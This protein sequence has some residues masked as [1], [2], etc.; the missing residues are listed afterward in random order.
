MLEEGLVGECADRL[1]FIILQVGVD[2]RWVWKLHSSHSY[3]VKSAYNYLTAVDIVPN[4]GFN[5]LLWL[6]VVPLKVNIFV[7]R[8]FLNRFAMKDNLCRRSVLVVSQV[9]CSALCG[10]LEDMD[11]LFF[12]C[13]YYGRL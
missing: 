1:S 9:S 6:K 10:G 5:H 7:W 8:L 13:D 3:T 11:H 12:R 4:E 2:D